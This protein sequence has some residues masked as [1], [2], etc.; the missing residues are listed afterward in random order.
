MYE[1]QYLGPVTAPEQ[2]HPHCE[3]SGLINWVPPPT[4]SLRSTF[5]SFL[6][7]LKMVFDM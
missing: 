5:F 1:E 2:L 4:I 7:F 6:A 3:R